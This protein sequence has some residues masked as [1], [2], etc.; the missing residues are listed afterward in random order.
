MVCCF[1]L[2]SWKALAPENS[3]NTETG[4]KID[5]KTENIPL[6]LGVSCLFRDLQKT[7]WKKR[8]SLVMKYVLICTTL[9]PNFIKKKKKKK[10]STGIWTC[11][12]G[13]M[14]LNGFPGFWKMAGRDRRTV[15]SSRSP[16]DFLQHFRIWILSCRRLI[17][18]CSMLIWDTCR[19]IITLTSLLFN[20]G[21]QESARCKTLT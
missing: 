3:L 6:S 17:S 15:M 19:P 16:W 18:T 12:T 7:A 1:V 5:A 9:T 10:A 14:I 4:W 20:S 2:V 13:S 21:L 11:G 8:Q